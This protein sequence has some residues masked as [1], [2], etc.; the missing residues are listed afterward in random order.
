MNFANTFLFGPNAIVYSAG[1]LGYSSEVNFPK[2]VLERPLSSTFDGAINAFL[3]GIGGCIVEGFIP[4]GARPYLA[5]ACLASALYWQIEMKRRRTNKSKI[6]NIGV[7]YTV[8]I[9]QPEEN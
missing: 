4:S 8:P 1:I 5:G 2:D 6:E 9:E 3:Y 7:T